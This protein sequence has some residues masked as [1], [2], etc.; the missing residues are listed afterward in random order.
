MATK[1]DLLE[2]ASL[3]E[4]SG[5]ITSLTRVMYVDSL[6]A[7]VATMID[8]LMAPDVPVP[9]AAHPAYGYLIVSTRSVEVISDTKVKILIGYKYLGNPGVGGVGPAQ[10]RGGSGIQQKQVGID[11]TGQPINWDY[12]GVQYT[13]TLDVFDPQ[14]TFSFSRTEQTNL[15]G[16]ISKNYT[17]KV[18]SSN[19]QGGN[20]GEWLCTN[21][22]FE[23]VSDNPVT[24]DVYAMTY[25]F[26][27]Q[28]GGWQPL[29]IPIDP[30]TGEPVPG[31][32]LVNNGI[33]R[34]DYYNAMNF[35]D[36][37]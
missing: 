18:N 11:N 9:G 17:G 8:A 2:G 4:E 14:S 5:R 27:F 21:V 12:N 25:E 3:T 30:D 37:L 31:A 7:G 23:L 13:G 1:T 32:T 22:S 36:L 28:E 24:P 29:T 26:Q 6:T 20:P 33:K 16:L 19:W 15:P 10:V 35:N 34:W